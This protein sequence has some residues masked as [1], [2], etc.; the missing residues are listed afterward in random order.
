MKRES[1]I[2]YASSFVSFLLDR[3]LAKD[4]EKIVLFG[5]VA[6]GDFDSESDIDLFIDTKKDLQKPVNQVFSLFLKSDTQKKWS[7]KGLKHELSLKVGNIEEWRLKRSVLS[8]GILLYGKFQEMP[9]DLKYYGLFALSLKNFRKSTK[10]SIWRKLYG[11]K[12]KTK[13]KTYI[14]SGIVEKLG[15]K[16][17]DNSLVIPINKREELVNFLKKEKI[18]YK[19]KEV[20]SDDF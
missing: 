2:A 13:S 11:Y 10:V 7:L 8:D 15:G 3:E 9:N 12:Q 19:I 4:I 20:W 16:R 18:D 17:M 6:R 14:F 1:L 5:S